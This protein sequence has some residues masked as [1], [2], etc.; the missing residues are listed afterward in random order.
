MKTE[1]CTLLIIG[2]GPGGYVCGI[3]AGQL[4]LDTIVVEGDRPGGTCLNVGCIPSKALIHAADEFAKVSQFAGDNE[5]GISTTAPR[6]DLARTLAWKDGIVKRLTG[7]VSSLLKK[8]G[9][10]VVSGTARILD[11]KTVEVATRDGPRRISCEH[12]VIATG[13]KP[14]ELPA[15][16]FGG[17]VI[18]STEALDLQELPKRLTVVGGGYIGLEIGTALAK[19]GAEVTVVEAADRILPQYD[20]EL[21]KPVMARLAALGITLHLSARASG[22]TDEGRA[23][24]VE[25]AEGRQEIAADK[26]LV[27]V[28]RAPVTRGFGLQDLG[29][30]MNGEFLAIDDRCATSMRGVYAIGDVTGDPML[31]HRAMAQGV[32]VAEHLAGQPALWDK[33][34]IPAVCFTDPEIVTVG[35]LPGDAAADVQTAVFPFAAN[36][37]SLTVERSDGFV[38]ILHAA[39]TGLVLGIQAVGAGVSELAGEFAL[40]IEMGA[41]LTDIAETI[42]AHPTLSETVQ[43][44]ALKGLGR[45]LHI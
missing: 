22:L 2:A 36:G 20:A 33:H 24:T 9:T 13:S 1:S 31:A 37:R 16:P 30:T 26:V 39:D 29:L 32:I 43:E 11:G 5:L 21:T 40:A 34:A 10:R 12:M 7:G 25:S 38:R 14:L 18:S 42:H 35:Q 23:L 28:G 6:I 8:S 3:R 4:G 41:T 19:L 17:P 15:L 27:T 45:A 44:T